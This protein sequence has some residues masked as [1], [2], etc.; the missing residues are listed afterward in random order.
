MTDNDVKDWR[1]IS[2][3]LFRDLIPSDLAEKTVMKTPAEHAF[4]AHREEGR[5]DKALV[6]M[7][8][9]DGEAGVKKV[10]EAL[11]EDTIIAMASRWMHYS[12]AWKTDSA[13][14][15]RQE[16]SPGLRDIWRAVFLSMT[17]DRAAAEAAAERLDQEVAAKRTD[18]V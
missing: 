4:L 12:K 8:L 1:D 9:A 6:T 5:V 3:L 10:F 15:R 18:R 14:L 13:E 17:V 16:L 7:A 2:S 11:S